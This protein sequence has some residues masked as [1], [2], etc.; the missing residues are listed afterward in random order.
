MR[1][2]PS[3]RAGLRSDVAARAAGLRDPANF[4]FRP[5]PS[6][7]LRGAGVV[8]PPEAPAKPGGGRPDIGAYQAD[9][10]DPW[11]P[12]CTFS[13]ACQTHAV[14]SDDGVGAQCGSWKFRQGYGPALPG[15]PSKQVATAQACCAFCHNISGCKF[16]T[17]NGAP[18]G[19][20]GDC[21]PKAGNVS[22]GGSPTMVSG[23]VTP[24]L[25][26]P[27]APPA[28]PP[29]PPP[30]PPPSLP[31]PAPP[32]ATAA[33]GF[34]NVSAPPFN[35]DSTGKTDV[36]AIL[37]AA[38][39]FAYDSFLVPFFPQGEY[40]VSY[41]LTFRTKVVYWQGMTDGESPP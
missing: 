5:G 23:G 10:E 36:T 41:T 31:P 11:V 39:D 14:K 16:W 19:G 21:Y 29:P 30:P 32:Q 2:P 33:N 34:V 38:I 6:S 9:D 40:L 25:P 28:P 18:P 22:G 4:D 37:Q 13:P 27:P 1:G 15:A 35:A 17:W 8:R 26:M 24:G 3:R 12:G 20:N 7:P